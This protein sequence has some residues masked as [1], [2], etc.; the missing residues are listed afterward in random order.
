MG[1]FPSSPPRSGPRLRTPQTVR[2][3]TCAACHGGCA[4]LQPC[5]TVHPCHRE[6]NYNTSVAAI[7]K[8]KR[9]IQFADPVPELAC[10]VML[11]ERR[12]SSPKPST[13]PISLIRRRKG[14]CLWSLRV[15]GTASAVLRFANLSVRGSR[16]RLHRRPGRLHRLAP[17]FRHGRARVLARV[18][19]AEHP[20]RG[21][22]GGGGGRGAGRARPAGGFAGESAERPI[23][24]P[25][26]RRNGARADGRR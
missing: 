19:L 10:A 11:A 15:I 22:R 13:L 2:R 3:H 17:T 8:T 5:A 18:E 20:D 21:L 6:P 24:S 9:T 14:R 1:D 23:V 26:R 4:L 7:N 12:A 25:A 16:A